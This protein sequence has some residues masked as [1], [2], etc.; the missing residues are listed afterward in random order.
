MKKFF[1]K[2][3]YSFPIKLIL[4]HLQGK[5]LLLLAWVWLFAAAG[6]LF[7]NTFGIPYLFLSPEYLNEVS[8]SS[9]AVVGIILGGFAMTFHIT[10]YLMDGH[11]Y[12]FLGQLRR[13]FTHYAINNSII[14]MIF[15][16]FYILKIIGFQ[17]NYELASNA[18][19]FIRLSGL[20]LG[21]VTMQASMY[22]Y[23]IFTNQ[24]VFQIIR[25]NVEK[26]IKKV[27]LARKNMLNR[28]K[29]EYNKPDIEVRTFLGTDFTFHEVQEPPSYVTKFAILKVFGQNSFN[30]VSLEFTAFG[31]IILIGIFREN[32]YFQIPAAASCILLLTILMMF[33][34]AFS[35]WFK[36]WSVL[37]ILLLL[38]FLNFLPTFDF[39]KTEYQVPG[40][41]YDTEKVDYSLTKL[42]ELTHT[43]TVKNDILN[44]IQI[45][46]NWKKNTGEEKPVLMVITHSGGGQR[47]SLWSLTA[48]QSLDSALNG[49][50][51][52]QTALI[53]GASGG[54]IGASYYRELYR[55]KTLGN[56]ENP[57]DS[58]YRTNISKDALNHVIFTML[59]ND[60]LVRLQKYDY[61]GKEYMADRG[62]AFERQILSNT[63]DILNIPVSEYREAEQQGLIPQLII[64]PTILNDGRKLFISAQDISYMSRAT[65]AVPFTGEQKV[66]GFEFMRA[67]KDHDAKD[68]SILTAL[69][70]NATYPYIL[71]NLVLP[72]N[73]EIEILDAGLVDNFGISDAIRFLLSFRN[74][75]S[76]NTSGI[77]IVTVRDSAVHSPPDSEISQTLLQ[78]FTIP[79]TGVYNNLPNLQDYSNDKEME[80][81][82]ALMTVPVNLVPIEY[83]PER[84]KGEFE[85]KR[86][87]L[88]WR[89]TNREK[90]NIISNIKEVHNILAI[91]K[92]KEL[93][94]C[95]DK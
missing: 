38:T 79:I 70:M 19:I 67:F 93:V 58:I 80:L 68:L 78:K 12:P 46:E 3:Y 49:K 50:L 92:I 17:R 62:V 47:A 27:P 6:E 40:L 91:Q 43:D 2:L 7:G 56:I 41:K 90:E 29:S 11:R 21:Y 20:I 44:G 81:L 37:A 5:I 84:N 54:L 36:R 83:I 53:T 28:Y 13:P 64:S 55:Q 1:D 59:V 45:L 94:N 9:F 73:P 60:L 86:A 48:M 4:H 51:M 25:E 85:S 87:T 74:W 30:A 33:A 89:L 72:S 61:K 24:D 10:C 22:T 26:K 34:G 15:L 39:F 95:K 66:K 52:N 57:N 69:R 63:N 16:A 76:K 8:F 77:V 82:K 14:P 42:R 75:I 65:I 88:N 31:A 18:D 32:P 23:F 71:P 35:Y